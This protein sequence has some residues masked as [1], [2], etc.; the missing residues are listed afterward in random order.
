[1]YQGIAY[2]IV[3][4]CVFVCRKVQAT[5]ARQSML[6]IASYALYLT[7]SYWFIAVLLAS[8]VTNFA[9]GKWLRENAVARS[10]H[11]RSLPESGITRRL[12][13]FT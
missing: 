5:Y 9:M 1:M 8:T 11:L 12:R 10:P 6:L 13:I 3:F 2:L 7:W 4:L